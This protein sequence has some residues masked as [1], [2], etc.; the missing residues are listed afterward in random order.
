MT[1]REVISWLESIAEKTGDQTECIVEIEEQNYNTEA[2]IH[3]V[4]IN[5][6]EDGSKKVALI[7]TKD[8]EASEE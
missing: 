1:V 8:D 3:T 4:C 6:Y 5:G 2:G 7:G